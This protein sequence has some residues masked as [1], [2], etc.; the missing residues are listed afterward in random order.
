M[1]K[2]RDKRTGMKTQINYQ[3]LRVPL[4]HRNTVSSS[5]FNDR[6]HV[7]T[8]KCPHQSLFL[9]QAFI[10]EPHPVTLHTV[11]A[12]YK[13]T[14]I[15][16]LSLNMTDIVPHRQIAATQ[17]HTE[18]L[19]A[20]MPPLHM[21]CQSKCSIR[22]FFF[23]LRT[24]H[25]FNSLLLVISASPRK[26]ASALWQ[27]IWQA[28]YDWAG[29]GPCGTW[30]GNQPHREQGGLQGAHGSLCGGYRSSRTSW[31]RWE[32]MG[33]RWTTGGKGGWTDGEGFCGKEGRKEGMQS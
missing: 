8:H 4:Q 24:H 14:D 11:C 12:I 2:P 32:D 31:F 27:P 30:P 33:W 7:L 18:L 21:K 17:P 15:C 23:F 9:A 3:T 26:D 16:H 13:N 25:V 28:P 22:P 20:V 5:L 1:Q 10:H 6:A 29:E 19:W